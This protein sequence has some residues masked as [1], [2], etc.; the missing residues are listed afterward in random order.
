MDSGP[1]NK[2][3]SS[4]P[5]VFIVHSLGL[6]KDSLTVTELAQLYACILYYSLC[7][8]ASIHYFVIFWPCFTHF[9]HSVTNCCT[10]V[11]SSQ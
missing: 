3:Y 11:V 6:W 7:S 2:P 9:S 5:C 4:I 1:I 10:V 8:N